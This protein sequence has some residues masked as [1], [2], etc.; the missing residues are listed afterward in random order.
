MSSPC[1]ANSCWLLAK[2]SQQGGQALDLALTPRSHFL[3][4][5]TGQLPCFSTITHGF[6]ILIEMEVYFGHSALHGECVWGDQVACMMGRKDL[7]WDDVIQA[8]DVISRW[9][10]DWHKY[11]HM[12][13]HS[14]S[15]PHA[16]HTDICMYTQTHHISV[17]I[18]KHEGWLIPISI[19]CDSELM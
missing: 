10:M 16:E 18:L 17:A 11:T 9:Y 19:F 2:H 12:C 4:S 1:Q 13:R 6:I 8:S 14:Q 7:T 5:F 3:W 15:H